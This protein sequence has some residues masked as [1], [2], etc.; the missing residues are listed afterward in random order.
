MLEIEQVP[1][2]PWQDPSRKPSQGGGLLIPARLGVGI[3][4]EQFRGGSNQNL[5][6]RMIYFD[7]LSNVIDFLVVSSALLMT[8]SACGFLHLFDQV[9]IPSPEVFCVILF[10][11][12]QLTK[13]CSR[14]LFSQTLGDWACGLRLLVFGQAKGHL[15]R[16]FCIFARAALNIMTGFVLLPLL[17]LYYNEDIAG[18]I[19]KAYLFKF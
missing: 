11:A 14:V 8:I 4:S 12:F 1:L 17:S 19:S 16:A 5:T 2:Q 10:S 13:I 18:K 6:R 15:V 7:L 9:Q 3:T